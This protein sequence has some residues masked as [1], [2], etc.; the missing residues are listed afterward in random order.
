LPASRLTVFQLEVLKEFFR[1]EKRF[2]LTGGGAE[3]V[4]GE[5][6]CLR[7]IEDR[8][9]S[10]ARCRVPLQIEKRCQR[11]KCLLPFIGE[12]GARVTAAESVTLSVPRREV[13]C[14]LRLERDD[15][16]GRSVYARW[17]K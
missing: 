7:A 11:R 8:S 16:A 1:R 9:Q 12:T 3:D 17:A 10:L 15:A 13:D 2:F 14:V 6:A 5:S 4:L